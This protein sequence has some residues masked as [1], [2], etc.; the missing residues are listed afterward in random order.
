MRV[1]ETKHFPTAICLSME[2]FSV[3]GGFFPKLIEETMSWIWSDL[4]S[5]FCSFRFLAPDDERMITWR[6]LLGLLLES[7]RSLRD[8]LMF[9]TQALGPHILV[10]FLLSQGFI[11][12]VHQSYSVSSHFPVLHYFCALKPMHQRSSIWETRPTIE[13]GFISVIFAHFKGFFA[14]VINYTLTQIIFN[15]V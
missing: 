15:Y 10:L 11:R 1:N 4:E 14:H 12:S 6:L 13:V 3:F 8:S 5:D 7:I 2:S 9:E